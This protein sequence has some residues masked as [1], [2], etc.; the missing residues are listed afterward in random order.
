MEVIQCFFFEILGCSH[1]FLTKDLE[2]WLTDKDYLDLKAIVN[3]MSV[4]NDVAERCVKL[5]SDNLTFSR[6]EDTFQDNLQVIEHDR[7]EVPNI[8]KKKSFRAKIV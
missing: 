3:D 2:Q 6:N 4:V 5:F 7:K 1:S 8:R